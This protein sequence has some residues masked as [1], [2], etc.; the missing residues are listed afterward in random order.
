MM[1]K[2]N[3]VKNKKANNGFITSL[4]WLKTTES[5]TTVTV[6]NAKQA[7]QT[8]EPIQMVSSFDPSSAPILVNY[9]LLFADCLVYKRNYLISLIQY[10]ARTTS[11]NPIELTKHEIEIF[12]HSIDNLSRDTMSISVN[13][14]IP[15]IYL[16]DVLKHIETLEINQLV[17]LKKAYNKQVLINSINNILIIPI[18]RLASFSFLFSLSF[19]ARQSQAA[20]LT[21]QTAIVASSS[22]RSDENAGSSSIRR[23]SGG[24]ISPPSSSMSSPNSKNLKSPTRS[25]S[26][27]S[28]EKKSSV[29]PILKVS[30]PSSVSRVELDDELK[31]MLVLS[32]PA[33]LLVPDQALILS[34]TSLVLPTRQSNSV[35]TPFYFDGPDAKQ[36]IGHYTIQEKTIKF[37]LF[38]ITGRREDV[39]NLEKC[40]KKQLE[41]Q[42]PYRAIIRDSEAQFD[43]AIGTA[44]GL[45]T[46]TRA[47]PSINKK[48]DPAK[49]ALVPALVNTAKN[50][51]E[52]GM[53][54]Q[55][56]GVAYDKYTLQD[57]V[58]EQTTQGVQFIGNKIETD[59]R[60]EKYKEIALKIQDGMMKAAKLAGQDIQERFINKYEIDSLDS[61]LALNLSI[62]T[63]TFSA[64]TLYLQGIQFESPKQTFN[65]LKECLMTINNRV[66]FLYSGLNQL[67]RTSPAYLQ[68]IYSIAGLDVARLLIQVETEIP[69][70]NLLDVEKKELLAQLKTTRST[71][72]CLANPQF[73]TCSSTPKLSL[74]ELG[75][76]RLH[77]T[78]ELNRVK[79]K[80]GSFNKYCKRNNYNN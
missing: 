34:Q 39:K 65:M 20:N 60:L 32:R 72:T 41:I 73:S 56:P 79:G 80:H 58:S 77:D 17:A 14:N 30:S 45:A 10:A 67:V 23:V 59:S 12:F 44:I 43:H 8:F 42:Q 19:G 66:I 28:T 70:G 53:E 76:Q 11:K 24:A 55:P 18:C 21:S 2:C 74:T 7:L 61:L 75:E 48:Q 1:K 64:D 36:Y 13:Q 52:S 5:K 51:V 69:R 15:N 78:F 3:F 54:V 26:H 27:R 6:E 35:Y 33:P 16:Q 62:V 50:M 9:D 68:H 49:G 46:G 29:S 31:T 57:L 63:Q 71:S 40:A 25:E 47:H 38:G 22:R 4:Y 37:N